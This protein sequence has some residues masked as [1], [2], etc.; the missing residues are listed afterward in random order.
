[1]PSAAPP[2]DVI[3]RPCHTS[4]ARACSRRAGDDHQAMLLPPSLITQI[5][6]GT[7]DRDGARV[8]DVFDAWVFAAGDSTRALEAW[9]ASEPRD[10][11]EA[12]DVYLAAL[13]REEQAAAVLAEAVRRFG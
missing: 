8:I 11:G 4:A 13:D 9:T 1:M 6:A 12:F 7:V 2:R 10:R 3:V 5:G